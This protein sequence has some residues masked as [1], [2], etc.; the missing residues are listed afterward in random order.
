MLGEQHEQP[1]V[2]IRA[3]ERPGDAFEIVKYLDQ[4]G[5]PVRLTD[6]EFRDTSGGLRHGKKIRQR[7]WTCVP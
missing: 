6:E 5:M 7:P 4:H 2:R 1:S 3:V